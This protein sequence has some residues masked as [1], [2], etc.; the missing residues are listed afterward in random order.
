MLSQ[1]ALDKTWHTRY[2]ALLKNKYVE[3]GTPGIVEMDM[4]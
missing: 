4:Y 1:S 3:F 2:L